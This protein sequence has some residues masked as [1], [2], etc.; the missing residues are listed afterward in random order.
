MDRRTFLKNMS[1]LGA[2]GF[3][4]AYTPRTALGLTA[5]LPGGYRYHRMLDYGADLPGLGGL[6]DL[7]G[8]AVLNESGQLVFGAGDEFG[9]RGLFRMQFDFAGSRPTVSNFRRVA[10]QSQALYGKEIVGFG[11][12]E[13]NDQGTVAALIKTSD[14]ELEV[15]GVWVERTPGD[16][17]LLVD[18]QSGLPGAEGRFEPVFGDLDIDENDDVIL[19]GAYT[20]TD[21]E[22]PET[23]LF[24]LPGAENNDDGARLISTNELAPDG[25]GIIG[26]LG[27]I[28]L[29]DEGE[30]QIQVFLDPEDASGQV[31]SAAA[32][33][34][35]PTALIGGNVH[36]PGRSKLKM[37]SAAAPI[38]PEL[39][40]AD[41][42]IK[43]DLYTG[44]RVG[45]GDTSAAIG[46]LTAKDQVLIFNDSTLIRTGQTSLGG[47]VIASFNPPVIGA[48]GLL[49]Y[50]HL[51]SDQTMELTVSD[52]SA[53]ALILASGDAVDGKTVRGLYHGFMPE[54]ADSAG[55]LALVVEFD[56]DSR[57][58]VIGI[59]A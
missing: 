24:Y 48:D 59:P 16:L 18:D 25:E 51:N 11:N 9:V 8:L 52:G 32:A 20:E 33:G 21:G 19:V 34:G 56:D 14:G 23:G 53:S 35:R 38:R 40:A 43:A 5:A 17:E 37:A 39:K 44:P 46:H 6:A 31:L 3:I 1:R 12:A 36:R 30:Y 4:A 29:D 55:R 45:P 13:T 49:Y 10:S 42:F 41:E 57:S 15:P 26:G 27:L 28:D 47:K 50:S 58:L 22:Q 2:A 7:P 54:Q